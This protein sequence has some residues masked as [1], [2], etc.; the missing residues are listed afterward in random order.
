MRLKLEV[1][2]EGE[3]AVTG[4][5]YSTHIQPNRA[6]NQ[7]IIRALRILRAHTL[8]TYQTEYSVHSP[9]SEP[10]HMQDGLISQPE[11]RIA[12][13]ICSVETV[14]KLSHCKSAEIDRKDKCCLFQLLFRKSTRHVVHVQ[15][16][17]Q[18]SYRTKD[19][20]T[21]ST[22]YKEGRRRKRKKL[23]KRVGFEPPL[24]RNPT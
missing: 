19:E 8:W 2:R 18:T 20:T 24:S 3:G 6:H 15:R 10:L 9:L 22:P 11:D 16:L 4:S 12:L 14:T 13:P 5:I 7:S 17:R 21:D 1:D 23:I